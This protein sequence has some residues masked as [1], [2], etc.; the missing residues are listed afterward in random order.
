MG[1]QVVDMVTANGSRVPVTLKF[2]LHTE[3]EHVKH[4]IQVARSTEAARLD[5][6]RLL[7]SLNASGTIISIDSTL[8]SNKLFGFNPLELQG[9][10]LSSCV[11]Q[12]GDW[13]AQ[14]HGSEADLLLL[15]LGACSAGA[16]TQSSWR[17]GVRVPSSQGQDAQNKAAVEAAS[18]AGAAAFL[19]SLTQ[20]NKQR[21][22]VLRL[23][24]LVG[25]E[26]DA[27]ALAAEGKPMIQV[28]G[29]TGGV[30]AYSCNLHFMLRNTSAISYRPPW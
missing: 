9:R 22:A 11:Q 23:R 13:V 15:L 7:L 10:T 16:S 26:D 3:G 12:V 29:M 18:G 4:V 20:G 8:C 21:P 28:G 27:L 2:S 6:K 24:S 25:E 19:S 5:S 30:Q 1:G 17:V 14:G